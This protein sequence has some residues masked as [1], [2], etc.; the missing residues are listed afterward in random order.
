M[1]TGVMVGIEQI[2]AR[3]REAWVRDLEGEAQAAGLI[4]EVGFG[5][6]SGPR[7]RL[8]ARV[9]GFGARGW[10]RLAARKNA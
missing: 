5:E 2:D 7:R 1:V 8:G 9:A 10:A 3:D 4:M 6:M